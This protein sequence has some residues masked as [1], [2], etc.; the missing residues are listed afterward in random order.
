M[1]ITENK[2]YEISVAENNGYATMDGTSMATP[3]VCGVL[4]LLKEKFI[5]EFGRKPTQVE[6]Y[7]QLIKNTIDLD[8]DKR[9]QGNGMVFL[10]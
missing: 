9:I 8:I 5:K 1:K 3:H 6:L 10:R 2:I 4:A 7:A